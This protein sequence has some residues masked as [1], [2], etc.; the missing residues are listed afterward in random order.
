M[1][2]IATVFAFFG[3]AA[4]LLAQGTVTFANTPSTLLSADGVPMPPAATSEFIFGLFLAPSTT[5]DSSGITPEL[6]DPAFQFTDT[7][8]TNH[9]SAPGRLSARNGTSVGASQGYV[10][11]STVDFIVR[12]WSANAGT[13]WAEAFATWNN[14]A[15]LVPMYIGTSTVGDNLILSGG[16]LPHPTIFG[17]SPV[18]QVP[19]FDMG[20]VPEPS[21]WRWQ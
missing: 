11:G 1:R 5:V 3:S 21:H 6:T 2:I 16:T 18:G 9:V 15:P 10:A 20:F 12:G 8:T 19:G 13:T 17:T 14:G 7:Y 4:L